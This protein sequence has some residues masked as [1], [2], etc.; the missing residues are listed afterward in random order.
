MEPSVNAEI[1]HP[2][3]HNQDSNMES[4]EEEEEEKEQKEEVKIDE[5]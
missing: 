1:S 2:L 4:L 3:K 5:D